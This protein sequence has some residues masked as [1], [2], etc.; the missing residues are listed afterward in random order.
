[1]FRLM[2]AGSRFAG[3]LIISVSSKTCHSCYSPFTNF[4]AAITSCRGEYKG[5][6]GCENIKFF[7]VR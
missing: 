6:T 4:S 7:L 3:N 1:M 2:A 5:F